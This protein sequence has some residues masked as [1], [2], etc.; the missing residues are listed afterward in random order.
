MR[1][2]AVEKHPQPSQIIVYI[3][4][5]QRYPNVCAG[6]AA[7]PRFDGSPGSG[8][9]GILFGDKLVSE[10]F[11][12]GLNAGLNISNVGGVPDTKAKIGLMLGLVAEWRIGGRF[13]L[14]PELLPF[15]GLAHV[16]NYKIA[17][18]VFSL[19]PYIALVFLT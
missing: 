4:L 14:Q 11:H 2:H 7:G 9:P 8:P 12:I 13:Y 10:R 16:A 15:S 6:G 1:R 18:L 17:V 3:S 19:V 5:C